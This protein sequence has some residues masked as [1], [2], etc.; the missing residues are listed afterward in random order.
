MMCITI[1]SIRVVTHCAQ[2][3]TAAIK[4]FGDTVAVFGS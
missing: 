1:L 4:A 3:H 2:L